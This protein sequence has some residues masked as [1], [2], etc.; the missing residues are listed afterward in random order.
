MSQFDEFFVW[1]SFA[2]FNYQ[3]SFILKRFFSIQD[4]SNIVAKNVMIYFDN[5]VDSFKSSIQPCISVDE[6]L[7][8]CDENPE[9][10]KSPMEVTKVQ[11]DGLWSRE[12][13]NSPFADYFKVH[14]KIPS[15][16]K[17]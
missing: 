14:T 8:V 15:R 2:V 6:C 4:A 13:A 7:E 12:R 5:S 11:R 3:K 1:K 9:A 10:C 17:T 16:L